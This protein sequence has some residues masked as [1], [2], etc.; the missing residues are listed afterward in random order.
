M[1]EDLVLIASII[2]P[3]KDPFSYT[4]IRSVFTAAE[5]FEQ[6]LKSI[7]SVRRALPDA[8]I[9]FVETS[10]LT[11]EQTSTLQSRTDYFLNANEDP[12]CRE[13]FAHSP[14]KGLGEAIQTFVALTY[15][16]ENK[17]QFRRMFKLSGRYALTQD[18]DPSKFSHTEYTFLK[19]ASS[20]PLSIS[21]VVYSFPYALL[22]KHIENIHQVV[23]FYMTGPAKGWEEVLPPLCEPRIE[24]DRIGVEGY[25]AV[26][27]DYFTC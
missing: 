6:T 4:T 2:N 13:F 12:M 17:I 14:K 27:G 23:S 22:N 8:K 10:D 5:R 1:S 9:L 16:Q 24:L 7:A 18:F 20:N 21:T 25:V 19:R 26:N 15:I 11:A 3:S